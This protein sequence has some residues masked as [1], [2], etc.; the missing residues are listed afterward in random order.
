MDQKQYILNL[1]VG[2]YNCQFRKRFK[3]SDFDLMSI[4][5][6]VRYRFGYEAFT[7]RT[8]DNFRLR[9]Y[10]NFGDYDYTN[11]YRLETDGSGG[12]GSLSDEVFVTTGMLDRY[13]FEQGLVKFVFIPPPVNEGPTDIILMENGEPLLMENGDNILLELA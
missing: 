7:K 5:P 4:T 13:F 10:F 3:I 12:S 6:R 8:D 2:A 1:M 9:A 11:L